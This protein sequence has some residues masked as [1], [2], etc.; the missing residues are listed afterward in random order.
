M[1]NCLQCQT[2]DI[3]KCRVSHIT[4]KLICLEPNCPS[5]YFGETNRNG[6]SRGCEHLK[7]SLSKSLDTIEKSV[8]ANHSWQCHEG[9]PI[10][11]K[12]KLVNRYRCDPT[13]RTNAEAIL[14]RNSNPEF[15]MNSKNEHNQP[16]D[17]KEKYETNKGNWEN[18]KIAKRT[19][20][21]K[22]KLR[23]KI[24]SNLNYNADSEVKENV[25]SITTPL[26]EDKDQPLARPL[27]NKL[28]INIEPKTMLTKVKTNLENYNP[29]SRILMIP[30]N[31]DSRTADNIPISI[32]SNQQ[33]I[34][35]DDSGNKVI[36]DGQKMTIPKASENFPKSPPSAL[37]PLFNK[38]NLPKTFQGVKRQRKASVDLRQSNTIDKYL[39]H[40]K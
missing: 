13:G 14:I 26:S 34:P 11:I 19:K 32:N 2:G 20:T 6:F 35:I 39:V 12:M 8:I 31:L 3:G 36:G 37:F 18:K 7:D 22:D 30:T 16:C 40:P 5:F 21:E 29:D 10:K 38:D 9:N 4:Y 24:S 1:E 33:N 17:V 23:T 25:V 27:N 28:K 15:L